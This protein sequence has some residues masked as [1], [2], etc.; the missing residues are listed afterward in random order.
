MLAQ[1]RS[2]GARPWRDIDA[3]FDG[4][5]DPV[6]RE[7]R[8]GV[9]CFGVCGPRSSEGSGFVEV[10]ES[11]QVWL[12]TVDLFKV[13]G[14][15]F[16]CGEFFGAQAPRDFGDGRERAE[17]HAMGEYGRGLQRSRHGNSF[18]TLEVTPQSLGF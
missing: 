11:I 8:C 1:E 13:H 2:G 12:G 16:A 5:R 18:Q 17:F 15:N 14:K 7:K 9:A 6:K 4:K 10:R 3:A